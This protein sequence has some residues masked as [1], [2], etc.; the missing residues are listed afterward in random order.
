M[1]GERGEF[2]EVF[3]ATL[4]VPTLLPLELSALDWTFFSVE[5]GDALTAG[6]FVK[7]ALVLSDVKD[8]F[9]STEGIELTVGADTG[10]LFFAPSDS[11]GLAFFAIAEVPL[12]CCCLPALPVLLL[13][14]TELAFTDEV[15]FVREDRDTPNSAEAPPSDRFLIDEAVPNANLPVGAAGHGFSGLASAGFEASDGVSIPL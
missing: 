13:L 10:L 2:R 8:D 11:V 15:D 4:L 5:V 12:S 6:F 3:E 9:F 1:E 7:S 14:C